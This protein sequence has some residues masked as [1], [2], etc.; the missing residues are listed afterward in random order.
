MEDTVR[1]N[2]QLWAWN[3]VQADKWFQKK[4]EIDKGFRIYRDHLSPAEKDAL[5][6][7]FRTL[8][9]AQMESNYQENIREPDHFG[10]YK[11]ALGPGGTGG[12]DMYRNAPDVAAQLKGPLPD[13]APDGPRLG[14]LNPRPAD[15]F[16]PPAGAPGPVKDTE[17]QPE[18]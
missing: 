11:P 10:I 3:E 18:N 6:G 4:C 1:L 2:A 16:K 15:S 13:A 9:P 7:Q 5:R 8:G 17:P 14:P 12:Y